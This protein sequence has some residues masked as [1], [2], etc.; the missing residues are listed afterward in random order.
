M[1]PCPVSAFSAHGDAEGVAGGSHGPGPI[2]HHT[3]GEQGGHV[4]HYRRIH[5]RLLQYAVRNHAFGPLQ[6]FLPGLEHKFHCAGQSILLFLQQF[7]GNIIYPRVVGS[8]VGLPSMWVLVAVTL[9]GSMMGV[10]GMLVYIPMF[11]V[12]YRLIREA[13]SDRLKTKQVPV[14]KFRS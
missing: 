14:E 7:E 8:S 11:S 10:L 2:E 12:L 4:H 6:G 1:G 3:G 9:G 13:V 5:V